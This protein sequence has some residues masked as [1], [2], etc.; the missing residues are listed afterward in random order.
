LTC[1]QKNP[2]WNCSIGSTDLIHI[3]FNVHWLCVG[4]SYNCASFHLLVIRRRVSK[5]CFLPVILINISRY[6]SSPT[7]IRVFMPRLYTQ[8]YI[9]LV[10]TAPLK[11]CISVVV[12]NQKSR[13]LQRKITRERQVIV[14]IISKAPSKRLT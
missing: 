13:S 8:Q 2:R 11:S 5:L 14:M 9:A 3:F 6:P 4:N 12:T 10:Y 7:E 1:E